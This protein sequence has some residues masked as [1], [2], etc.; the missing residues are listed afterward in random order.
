MDET[1]E[2]SH[3]KRRENEDAQVPVVPVGAS[4]IRRML[5]PLRMGCDTGRT[6]TRSSAGLPGMSGS[7]LAAVCGW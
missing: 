2:R 4:T 3:R 6:S 1:G 7:R 5:E